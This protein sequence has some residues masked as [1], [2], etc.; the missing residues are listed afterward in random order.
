MNLGGIQQGLSIGYVM[1]DNHVIIFIAKW[2]QIGDYSILV[3][4]VGYMGLNYDGDARKC[5]EYYYWNDSQLV[6]YDKFV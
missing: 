2:N 1:K 3:T 6:V 4:D 5:W